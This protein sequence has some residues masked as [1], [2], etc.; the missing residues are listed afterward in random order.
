M[1]EQQ[2]FMLVSEDGCIVCRGDS[3]KELV[4]SASQYTRN[5]QKK[6]YVYE[7]KT[8]IS[9]RIEVDVTTA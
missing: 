5:T 4:K 6:F 7:A 3:E 1:K 9:S 2:K 8:V